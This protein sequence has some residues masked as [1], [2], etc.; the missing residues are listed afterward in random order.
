[1]KYNCDKEISITIDQMRGGYIIREN[2]L[3]GYQTQI[4]QSFEELIDDLAFK[5]GITDIGERVVL[6]S[7][8]EPKEKAELGEKE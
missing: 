2:R 8:R 5:F 4:H 3:G 1:M 7:T 6:S